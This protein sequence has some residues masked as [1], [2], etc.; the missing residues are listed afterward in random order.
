MTSGTTKIENLT[1][2]L[3]D[4]NSLLTDRFQEILIKNNYTVCIARNSLE[5]GKLCDSS[6]PNIILY[7]SGFSDTSGF[8]SE[9]WKITK[10]IS[11][12]KNI[13]VLVLSSFD[14]VEL[15]LEG[16]KA[17]MDHHIV[18]PIKNYY[19]PSR[20]EEIIYQID[21]EDGKYKEDAKDKK[22]ED[23]FRIDFYYKEKNYVFDINFGQ[24]AHF[25]FSVL[26]N[27]VEQN[28]LLLEVQQKEKVSSKKL[29]EISLIHDISGLSPEETLLKQEMETAIE[30]N[31]F[32]LY[33]QA[34]I[35]LDNGKISGFESLIRWN[36]PKR[37]VVCPDDFIPLA[38][39]TDLITPIGFWVLEEASRQLKEWQGKYKLDPP[40]SVSFNVSTRQFINPELSERFEDIVDRHGLDYSTIRPEITESILM[41]DMES[42]NITLLKL[43]AKNF[44]LYMDDFGTGYSSLSY[45]RHFPVDVLKIDKSFVE[46]IN[47]DEESEVIV[48]TIIGLAHNLNMKVVAE[49][50]E[51]EEHLLKLREFKSNYGQ[52]YLF[53]RPVPARDAEEL[54]IRDLTW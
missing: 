4:F 17:G 7:I 21:Q 5:I 51:T 53:S 30:K 43:K 2:L 9:D 35:S 41:D 26:E 44:L 39:K 33:Y 28:H 23:S 47:I 40:L 42:A 45:L 31:Q 11:D 32:E 8:Q 19:L 25:L 50:V 27:F 49:G 10:N 46:W 3:I 34:I 48:R 13:P 20:I 15:Y 1:V 52:G 22:D 37:G 12:E 29:S 38:E 6:S 54:L 16:I 18:T 24:L 36:H 14:S